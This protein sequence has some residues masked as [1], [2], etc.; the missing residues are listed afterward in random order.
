MEEGLKGM[1]HSARQE[2][3]RILRDGKADASRAL[4]ILKAGRAYRSSKTRAFEMFNFSTFFTRTCRVPHTHQ[5]G[6]QLSP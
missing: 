3:L 2:A 6:P 4:E 1:N 5:R